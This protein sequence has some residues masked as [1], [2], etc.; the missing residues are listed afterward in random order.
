MTTTAATWFYRKPENDAYLLGER[1]RTTFW[2]ARFGGLWLEAERTEPPLAMRGTYN[3]ANVKMEWEPAKWFRL[4]SAPAAPA[5]ARG[6]SN[7]LRYKPTLRYEDPG[8]H[9]VWEWWL[10]SAEADKRWQEIQGKPAFR[11]PA[12]LDREN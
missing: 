2:D 10:N 6:V 11:N 12:R 1:V 5:L 7:I 3:G 4:A 9:T 8:G